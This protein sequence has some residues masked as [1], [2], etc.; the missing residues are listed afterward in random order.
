MST[1]IHLSAPIA[2]ARINPTNPI[3]IGSLR[4]F[5]TFSAVKV[6]NTVGGGAGEGWAHGGSGGGDPGDGG[7]EGLGGGERH[8]S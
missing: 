5:A 6:D 8:S 4:I 7:G 3:T 2:K 1:F